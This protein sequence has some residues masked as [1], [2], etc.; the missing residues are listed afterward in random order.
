MEV[1]FDG[2]HMG[3]FEGS[4]R[5]VIYPGSRLIEQVAVLSTSEPDTA[6]YYDAG[7]RMTVDADRRAGGERPLARGHPR[8]VHDLAAA[9]AQLRPRA[10]RREPAAAPGPASAPRGGPC[11]T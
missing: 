8:V 2:L 10:L 7:V 11:L 4:V 6:Y 1:A 5:Y 9:A 3:I